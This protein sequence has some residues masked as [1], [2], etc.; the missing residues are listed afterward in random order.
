MWPP[1]SF[2]ANHLDTGPVWEVAF[3]PNDKTILTGSEQ[4]ALLWD[5]ARPEEPLPACASWSC[6]QKR[7]I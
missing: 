5:L 3:N 4:E 1:R 7:G 6:G 2:S